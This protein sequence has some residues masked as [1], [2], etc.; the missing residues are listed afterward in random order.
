MTRVELAKAIGVDNTA[1]SCWEAGKYMPRDKNRTPLA[2]VLG[3]EVHDLFDPREDEVELPIRATLLASDEQASALLND[4]VKKSRHVKILRFSYPF[5]T[6]TR[7]RYEFRQ[8]IAARILDGSLE[9]LRAEVFYNLDRLKEV[10]SNIFRFDGYSY[11]VKG[12]AIT[13]TDMFPGIDFC[14]G[15]QDDCLLSAAW[16]SVPADDRPRLWLSGKPV[17]AFVQAY[18]NEVWHRGQLLN[19]NGVHDLSAVRDLAIRLGLKSDEW[20]SFLESARRFKMADGA[21]PMP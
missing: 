19:I 14:W 13:G 15:D 6:A 8:Y 4:L 10:L 16:N 11:W 1:L 3:V 7:Y 20:T 18:W 21:P 2:R 9:M 17:S 5:A 12:F